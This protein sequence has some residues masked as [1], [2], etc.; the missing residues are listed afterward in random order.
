MKSHNRIFSGGIIIILFVILTIPSKSQNSFEDAVEQLSS[1][2]VQGY[3]QPL[4]DGFGANINSGF[5]GSARIKRLG[6]T[7]RLQ[8]VGMG[9]LIGNDEKTYM[10]TPPEPYDQEPVETATIFGGDGAVVSHPAG[11]TYRFQN[12]QIDTRIMP[13]AAPQLTIGDVFGTQLTIR[14]VPVPSMDDF[15]EVNFVGVGVRHSISQYFPLLPVDIA[16]GVFY[17]T[18]SIGDFV[19]AEATAFSAQ[20]SKTFLLLTLYGGV[21]YESTDVNLSYTY[22]GPLPPGDQSDR[23]VSINFKGENEIRTTAGAS[24]ALGILHVHADISIGKVTVV[25]AGLGLGI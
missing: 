3:I 2:N 20:V 9:T 13:F 24:L 10:A 19:D 6:L 22:T 12:G 15:P 1:D 16:A 7:L 8:V 5:P 17:Q 11:A 18:L 21:Q 14:Y 25:S 4:L 23:N